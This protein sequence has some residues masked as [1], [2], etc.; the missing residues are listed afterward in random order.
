MLGKVMDIATR[1]RFVG[2]DQ[3]DAGMVVVDVRLDD[4]TTFAGDHLVVDRAPQGA[5][6]REG[7]VEIL[8]IK[9][10]RRSV[11]GGSRSGVD[12][13]VRLASVEEPYGGEDT[14]Q[15]TGETGADEKAS[16][17]ALALG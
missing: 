15:T 1:E 2:R 6:G 11:R 7:D 17:G 8:R 5:F 4:A 3:N 10:G 9:D 13:R 12:V 16:K 14:Q